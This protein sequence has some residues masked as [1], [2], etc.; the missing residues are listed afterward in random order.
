MLH[1]RAVGWSTG[2][3]RPFAH[4][5][6]I[7]SRWL[8]DREPGNGA[9]LLGSDRKLNVSSVS[10]RATHLGRLGGPASMCLEP[11]AHGMSSC[12][13]STLQTPLSGCCSWTDTA[14]PT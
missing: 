13:C 2:I 9:C 7:A 11:T 12:S 14:A 3:P 8:R 4:S 5:E 6:H 1:V 10:S